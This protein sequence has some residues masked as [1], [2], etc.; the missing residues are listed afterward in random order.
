M[1]Y[2][3]GAIQISESAD[4]PVLRMVY[5]AGHLTIRQLY[6]SLNIAATAKTMW[7]SFRW[8]IRRLVQHEFLE[9][10]EV[11]GLGAVLSL[12]I[13]GELFLQSKEPTIVER[14][15]RTGRGNQRD[16]V[17]H[18]VD[19]FEIQMALRR[20]GVVRYW[21]FETEIRAQNDFTTC[22][23]R[24]D[25]DAIITFSVNG[26]NARVALEYERTC[27]ST[28]EYERICAEL[29]L[30]TRVSTFLYL[31]RNPQL[32]SFL[33]H[34]LRLTTRHLYVGAMQEFCADPLNADLIDVRLGIVRRLEECLDDAK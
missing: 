1:R 15:S 9:H 12:G 8:R 32:H 26:S 17:W 24:K 27:K 7:D 29:N 25:Y 2:A 16:Q 34:G 13:N 20:A 31:A 18:D 6:D 19:V 22:G 14:S 11:D 23:Y 33:L 21:Q 10:T 3:P 30:E 4:L 28:S 5:R